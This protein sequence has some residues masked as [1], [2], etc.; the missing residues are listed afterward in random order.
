MLRL[1]RRIA[2]ISFSVFAGLLVLLAAIA[3]FFQ[4]EVKAKLVSELNT[5]L[6]APL[7]QTGIDLTLIKRFPQAS[8]RIRDAYMEEVRTDGQQ[9]DTLLYAKDLYLEFSVFALITGNYTVSEVHGT[10]VKLYPGL[11]ANGNGNWEVWKADT[12]ATSSGSSTD[13]DLRR[14]TFDGLRGRFRDDRSGLEVAINSKTRSGR[15]LP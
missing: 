1:F 13:I 3:Y 8:L 2:L 6:T 10:D 14:V 12:S 5:H 7:H 15:A 9:P 4:D 11:D